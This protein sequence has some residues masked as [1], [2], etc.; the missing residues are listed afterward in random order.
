MKHGSHDIPA[1]S[2]NDIRLSVGE[3][4]F[5][6]GLRL[7]ESGAVKQLCAVGRGYE[8]TVQGTHLYSVYVEARG[9][10]YGNCTCYLGQND[11]LCKHIIAL[12]IAAVHAY[13]PDATTLDDTPL[14]IA[15]C[16]GE[17]RALTEAERLSVK[18]EITAA[19]RHIKSYNGPSW[20]WF[21]YQ[22]SLT[23]GV[24]TLLLALASLPVCTESVDIVI[25][26]L[27]RLDRKLLDAVDDSDGTVGDGMIQ[28]VEL[29]NLFTH[30]D[31]SL[32]VYIR[33]R[34]PSGEM[35]DW[36]NEYHPD[37]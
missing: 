28:I 25:N 5:S 24:R 2:L 31:P 6:K 3:R 12:A 14:G 1:Y 17:V 33:K 27:K 34:L 20:V 16:S 36:Q 19:L 32:E 8:A 9:F 13:R 7:Y 23:Q 4:E 15:V 30:L 22:D 26:L 10:D 37:R 11:E 21:Q 35:F 29:L 18:A